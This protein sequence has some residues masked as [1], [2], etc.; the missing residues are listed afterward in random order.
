M[1]ERL[2]GWSGVSRKHT[3][4]EYCGSGFRSAILDPELRVKK[5]F[6]VRNR[7][8]TIWKVRFRQKSTGSAKE[9]T[10]K[11]NFHITFTVVSSQVK[12][13]YFLKVQGNM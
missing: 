2:V 12:I 6:K 13:I 5:F 11:R 1:Y 3:N 9:P 8:R 7:I 10:T 4:K